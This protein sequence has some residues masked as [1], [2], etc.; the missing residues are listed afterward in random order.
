MPYIFVF[1]CLSLFSS[2]T[3]KQE[4]IELSYSETPVAVVK[5][6]RFAVH[7]L[8][9]PTKLSEV[10]GPLIGYLNKNIKTV[11]FEL[12]A[13]NNYPAYEGKIKAKEIEFGLPNPYQTL[14][15]LENGYRI[16]GK[17]GDDMNFRGVIVVRK[18]S[19]IKKILDLKGK[20]ISYPAATALAATMMPQDFL[21]RNGLNL[22][23]ETK[24]IYVGSQESSI[25]SVFLKSSQAGATWPPP[26]NSFAQ[27]NPDKAKELEVLWQTDTLPN[28]G[29]IVRD[30]VATALL[31]D[32]KR[33]LF[34]LHE[35]EEGRTI[36][37]GIG[38]SRFEPANEKTFEPV[39][40]FLQKFK[41]QVR[42]PE[43][44]L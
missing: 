11:V 10:F 8:H 23:K 32:V 6:V 30:D 24:S 4:K 43:Q 18:D 16:F 12:E 27:S 38:L 36:L 21:I 29:L 41:K 2:C 28:N 44:E 40:K 39:N 25:M 31:E 9:N 13:S 22:F 42:L 35:N 1:L 17:M 15:A 7:P 14:M 3:K 20:T 19:G 37:A 5:R 26:W 34:T 33:V